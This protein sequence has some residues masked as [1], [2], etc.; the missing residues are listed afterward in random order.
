MVWI[1]M[2]SSSNNCHVYVPFL[3]KNMAILDLEYVHPFLLVS[4]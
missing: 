4:V 3:G 2:E 1:P